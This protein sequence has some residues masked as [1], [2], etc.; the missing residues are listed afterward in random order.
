MQA[1]LN[2]PL[3]GKR[4]AKGPT[5]H[6]LEMVEV[7]LR[8]QDGPISLN[9]LKVLLPKKVMHS[10]LRAAVEHY[11]RLGCVVEGSKGVMWTLNPDPEFWSAVAGWERR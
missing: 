5:L 7:V 4:S 1:L 9:R 3:P 6:T 10:A 2:P 8:R 11:K